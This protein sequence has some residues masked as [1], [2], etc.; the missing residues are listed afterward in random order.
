M[1]GNVIKEIISELFNK[2][3]D[4][5]D[6]GVFYSKFN[7]SKLQEVFEIFI[8][9]NHKNRSNDAINYDVAMVLIEDHIQKRYVE[10]K[11]ADL[12]T[13]KHCLD[14]EFERLKKQLIVRYIDRF[15]DN[16]DN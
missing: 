16:S 5:D 13:F 7:D 9:T 2:N 14:T 1:S 12:D 4:N 8:N 10:M 6:L 3:L 15:K 11:G